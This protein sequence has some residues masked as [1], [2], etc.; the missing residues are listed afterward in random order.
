MTEE[1]QKLQVEVGIMTREL[2]DRAEA[3]SKFERE[4]QAER[5]KLVQ[6][7]SQTSQETLTVDDFF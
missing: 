2:Q 6:L 4:F 7:V 1:N 5:E 3:L